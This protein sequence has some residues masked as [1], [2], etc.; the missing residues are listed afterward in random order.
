MSAHIEET[1][2]TEWA[3]RWT[4]ASTLLSTG[5]KPPWS[6]DYPRWAQSDNAIVYMKTI[7]TT[8]TVVITE[9]DWSEVST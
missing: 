5:T 7:T 2:E 6:A 8:T 3:V 9:T 1:R 4:P